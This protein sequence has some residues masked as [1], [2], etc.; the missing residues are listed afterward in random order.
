MNDIQSDIKCL[1]CHVE[2]P[3]ARV[4]YESRE[5][6]FC[7]LQKTFLG[8]KIVQHLSSTLAREMRVKAH[9]ELTGNDR[10]KK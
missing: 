7:D 9:D 3:K 2:M 5:K 10:I 8:G 1:A 6:D 4:H